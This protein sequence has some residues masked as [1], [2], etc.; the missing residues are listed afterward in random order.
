MPYEKIIEIK[1]VGVHNSYDLELEGPEHHFFAN[2]ICVSNSHGLSYSYMTMQC[3]FLKTYYPLEFYTCLIDRTCDEDKIK[4]YCLSAKNKGLEIS[5]FFISQTRFNCTNDGEKTIRIGFKLIKGFGEKA[6]EELKEKQDSIKSLH[7]FLSIKWKKLNKKCIIALAG[8]GAFD[9][10]GYTRKSVCEYLTAYIENARATKKNKKDDAEIEKMLLCKSE[11]SSKERSSLFKEHIGF[12]LGIIKNEMLDKMKEV[13]QKNNIKQFIEYDDEHNI[14]GGII[15]DV[16]I[17][18]TKNGNDFYEIYVNDG[19][20][21]EKIKIWPWKCDS[22][23]SF[24]E[25]KIIII[26]LDND[27]K[28]GFSNA[29]NGLLKVI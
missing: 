15:E 28:W 17:K 26:Q 8:V 23:Y 21:K 18:K 13:F 12:D 10:F 7:D 1:E 16:K 22:H 6:W 24:D 14:I 19:Q 2:D 27:E 9:E 20:T 29:Q 5:S 4:K 3:L 11:Y 25:G